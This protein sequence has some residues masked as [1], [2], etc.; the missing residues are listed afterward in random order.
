MTDHHFLFLDPGNLYILIL[1]LVLIFLIWKKGGSSLR[2]NIF[3][4]FWAV[5]G[6]GLML[7]HDFGPEQVRN[8]SFYSVVL[9]SGATVLLMLASVVLHWL[10]KHS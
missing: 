3:A 6:F 4:A 7:V 1:A 10:K 5:L 9:Y 2:Q 8:F